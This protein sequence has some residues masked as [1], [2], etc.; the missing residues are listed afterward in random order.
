MLSVTKP[1][2]HSSFIPSVIKGT[3]DGLVRRARVLNMVLA[4]SHE[5]SYCTPSPDPLSRDP[6]T[7]HNE[8]AA[9][10]CSRRC[11]RS[12]T[13]GTVSRHQTQANELCPLR[14]V[15]SSTCPGDPGEKRQGHPQPWA[16][17]S[18]G[19]QTGSTLWEWL[20][21]AGWEGAA[22]SSQGPRR[23]STEPSGEAGIGN[24]HLS[25]TPP[26]SHGASS[27]R[28]SRGFS[29]VSSIWWSA[30]CSWPQDPVLGSP[31]LPA[32]GDASWG[33]SHRGR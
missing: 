21:R 25:L 27:L 22:G 31:A 15:P 9:K 3:E 30:A 12:R 28:A 17:P 24:D 4:I 33:W 2:I 18:P 23:P 19:L 10:G 8:P 7:A 13:R 1:F 11:Q 20:H 32:P 26:P 16:S 6:L 5:A 14:R 29:T